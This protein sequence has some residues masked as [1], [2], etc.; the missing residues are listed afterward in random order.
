MDDDKNTSSDDKMTPSQAP[1]CHICKGIGFHDGNICVCISKYGRDYSRSEIPDFMKDL[2]GMFS[3]NSEKEGKVMAEY[4]GPKS[5]LMD[6]I[7]DRIQEHY[8]DWMPDTVHLAREIEHLQE[9]FSDLLLEA[10]SND[11]WGSDITN[12]RNILRY[13]RCKGDNDENTAKTRKP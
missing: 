4:N 12:A 5:N 1:K 8:P 6:Y 10:E 13:K 11:L 2:F 7:C 3:T 9:V